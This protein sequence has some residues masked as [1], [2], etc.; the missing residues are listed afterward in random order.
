MIIVVLM[1]FVVAANNTASA[2]TDTAAKEEVL[3][4]TSILLGGGYSRDVSD[5]SGTTT[6]D[7]DLNRNQ[8][9]V[10]ARFLWKPGNL[11][12]GGIEVGY[13]NFYSVTGPMGG[14]S[15]RTAVPIYFV[16]SMSP[17]ERLD[18]TIGYGFGLLSS[19]VTG[20]GIDVIE[21]STFSNAVLGAASYRVPVSKD[22][23]I[24]GEVRYT[25][26]DK[27][28]DNAVAVSVILRYAL[29]EY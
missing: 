27:L 1:L 3:Y 14:K 4:S 10:F 20:P 8:F 26:F 29:F 9:S 15:V 22:L 25:R 28:G 23:E 2:Q 16:F 21:S 5:F 6:T 7:L 13:M 18:L 11:L 17:I 19:V 24:G 12:T